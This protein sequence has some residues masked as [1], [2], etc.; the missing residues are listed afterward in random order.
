M[1]RRFERAGAFWEIDGRTRSEVVIRW[2]GE[3]RPLQSLRRTFGTDIERARFI[4]GEIAKQ[5]ARGYV[6][7]ADFAPDQSAQAVAARELALERLASFVGP[8]KQYAEIVQQGR[9][10][11]RR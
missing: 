10:I 11:M 1:L 6:E 2:G 9:S 8:D 5:L 3:G 4:D 7:R